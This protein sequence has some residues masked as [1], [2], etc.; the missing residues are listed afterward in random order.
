[1]TEA[2][3]LDERQVVGVRTEALGLAMGLHNSYLTS[4][5]LGV[6]DE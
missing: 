1:M 4:L 2:V 5:I 6:E 3:A